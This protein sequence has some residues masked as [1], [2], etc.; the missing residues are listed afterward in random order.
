MP[1]C[2]LTRTGLCQLHSAPM[3]VMEHWCAQQGV[4][5]LGGWHVLPS[6]SLRLDSCG[7]CCRPRLV[8]GLCT[9]SGEHP[10]LL[11][12]V[13][14][15]KKTDQPLGANLRGVKRQEGRKEALQN[16]CQSPCPSCRSQPL[17]LRS[18]CPNVCVRRL[19]S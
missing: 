17:P 12:S 8:E 11:C 3:M 15:V 19:D 9:D 1:C 4:G 10:R 16:T 6:G 2:L 18:F 14:M 13:P 5:L 7:K